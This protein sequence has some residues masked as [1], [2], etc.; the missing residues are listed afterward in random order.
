MASRSVCTPCLRTLRQRT[1]Q[2]VARTECNATPRHCR[3]RSHILQQP[4][5][6]ALSSSTRLAATEKKPVPPPPKQEYTRDP[7]TTDTLSSLASTIRNSSALRSTT[8]PYVAYGGTETLLR[9][10]SATCSYTVP[11]LLEK[12]PRP[13]PRNAAGQEVGVGEGWWFQPKGPASSPYPTGAGLGLEVTFNSWAQV[14]F[15]HMYICTA[16]LRCFPAAHAPVWH[17]NLLDHFFYAAEER[18]A[19]SHGM[20]SRGMRNKYLKDLWTQWR[21]CL[22]SYDEGLIKGDAVLGTAVWRNIFQADA[23]ASV[24]DV[25]VVTAYLRR[26]LARV[27]KIPEGEFSTG[28]I[29][30]EDP[31]PAFVAQ[32]L[33]RESE[34]MARPFDPEDLKVLEEAA[35]EGEN[36]KA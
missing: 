2:Q 31:A 1:S 26:E 21:G 23:D 13:A 5:I 14:L 28:E 34:W 16:K 18:M 12:P 29:K 30:F 35:K 15:L 17:Q 25:A 7:P 24:A 10:C 32:V 6:R 11:S 22:L 3:R 36:K 4:H 27:D 33:G 19:T 20:S 8:E 9:A